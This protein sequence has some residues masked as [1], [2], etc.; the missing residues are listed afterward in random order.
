[1]KKLISYRSNDGK[2]FDSEQEC[3]KHESLQDLKSLIIE[4]IDFGED[5]TIEQVYSLLLRMVNKDP[6]NFIGLIAEIHSLKKKGLI[7]IDD[8]AIEFDEED[9][10]GDSPKKPPK[11]KLHRDRIRKNY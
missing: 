2:F 10:E 5:A 4:F 11:K 8:S 6:V 7:E 1:M 3:L 9:E